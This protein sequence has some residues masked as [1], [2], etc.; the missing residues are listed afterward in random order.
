[1]LNLISNQRDA[2]QNYTEISPNSNQNG[3]HSKHKQQQMLVRLRRKIGT[4]IYCWWD[5]KLVQPLWE[6]VWRMLRRMGTNLLFDPAIPLLGIYTKGQKPNYQ[7]NPCA[8]MFIAAQFT[9]GTS[10][11][12][13]Q[14]M[15]GLQNYGK[16]TQLSFTQPQRRILRHLQGNGQNWRILC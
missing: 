13:H 4:L 7:I 2:N 1:M 14:Q 12:V 16:C 6:K 11:D 10:Q 8:S 5:C 9:I 15:N 3:N